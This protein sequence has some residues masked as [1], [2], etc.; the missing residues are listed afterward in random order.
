MCYCER[1][2]YDIL[3]DLAE[4]SVP[5]EPLTENC[6]WS[7]ICRVRGYYPFDVGAAYWRELCR[8]RGELRWGRR[9]PSAS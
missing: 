9:Y 8:L 5:D 2:T 6:C 4:E 1:P 7:Q 3:R